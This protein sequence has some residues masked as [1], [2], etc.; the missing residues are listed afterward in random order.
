MEKV[1]L[2][3]NGFGR[4]GR[5]FVRGVYDAVDKKVFETAGHEIQFQI[6]AIQRHK[7]TI[8]QMAYLLK[9]DSIH[10]RFHGDVAYDDENLIIN[11]D[12]IK[13]VQ[14]GV[15][16][17]MPWKELGVD[18]VLES[19]GVN[20]KAEQSMAHIKAGAKKVII[21]AP[22]K[23]DGIATFVMGVN[24]EAYN[25]KTDAI[26]SNASCTTNCLAP[27]AKVLNDKIGI[28]KGLMTTVHSFTG[29]QS[30]VDRSH[31]NNYRAR[32]ATLSMVPT[33]TGAA[34]A[35]ALVIPTLKGKMNGIALRVPTPD[36]SI[37]DLCF[38]PA[39]PV[40]ADEVNGYIKAAS[41]DPSLSRYIGYETDDCVSADFIH[42]SRSTIFAP[43]QTLAMDGLVKVFSWYDNEWGYT[44][45]CIDLVD[46]IISR[47]L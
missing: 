4:I 3:I 20:T 39:R 2:A 19:S 33:T 13:V 16:G 18:L 12:K 27:I 28:V 23:G 46:Y 8:E 22:G 9:Y 40:T 29:D 41:E 25:P 37:V 30:L 17:E 43:D 11:G 32:A 26:I 44:C 24:E 7:A 5:L 34:K 6:V 31:K 14:S 47:G 36:V 42:D 35:V 38:V 1:R 21:T 45:R 15:P 10:G